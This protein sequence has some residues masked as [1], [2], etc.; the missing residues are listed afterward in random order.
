MEVLLLQGV[1]TDGLLWL[2]NYSSVWM[3]FQRNTVIS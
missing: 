1:N 3:R 2:A